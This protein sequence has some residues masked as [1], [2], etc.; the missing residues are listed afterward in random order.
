MFSFSLVSKLVAL[1]QY[2]LLM[3]DGMDE[4]VLPQCGHPCPLSHLWGNRDGDRK[5][6]SSLPPSHEAA[7]HEPLLAEYYL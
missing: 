3:L 5:C 4:N 7:L 2:D 1:L 6:R